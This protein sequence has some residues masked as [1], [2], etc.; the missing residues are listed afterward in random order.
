[1]Q[2][3]QATVVQQMEIAQSVEEVHSSRRGV[4]ILIFLEEL[5]NSVCKIVD[6]NWID[7]PK[8]LVN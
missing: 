4:N 2:V 7:I 6:C 5:H 8:V 3:L 1:M